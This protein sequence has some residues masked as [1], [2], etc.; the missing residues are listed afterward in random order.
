MS[1]FLQNDNLKEKLFKLLGYN[2]SYN[3]LQNENFGISWLYSIDNDNDNDIINKFGYSSIYS[4]N[5]NVKFL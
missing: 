1:S 4:N 2:N 3:S 5:K